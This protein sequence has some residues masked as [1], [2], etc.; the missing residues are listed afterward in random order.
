[1]NNQDFSTAFLV[2]QTTQQA[3]DAITNVRG[4]WS[5]GIEGDTAQLNDEF[6]YQAH[7]LHYS[8]IKLVEVVPNKKIVWLVK[9]NYFKFT[10]DKSEWTG[11]KI[12]FD[13]TEQDGKT[14]VRFTHHNLNTDMECFD[15]CS[16][17]WTD[18]INNSLRSLITMG[19]GKPNEVECE[20]Q[21]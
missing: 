17:C 20:V 10:K 2:D 8:Q 5:A 11:S 19:K 9:Y 21:N 14:Q 15:I 3:F 16:T 12:S 1:M 18:Y 7:D 4:W 13:I 6:V